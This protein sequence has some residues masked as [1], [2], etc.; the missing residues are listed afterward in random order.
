[1]TA[2]LTPLLRSTIRRLTPPPLIPRLIRA[3]TEAA[4]ADPDYRRRAELQMRFLLGKSS[5]AGEIEEIAYRYIERQ[6]WRDEL[7]WHPRLIC[8][9][10]VD[11]IDILRRDPSRP[12]ILNFM[13]HGQYDGLHPSLAYHGVP[14]HLVAAG[15][16]MEGAS[17]ARRQHIKVVIRNGI[18]VREA[19]TANIAAVLKPGVT[20]SIASDVP[21]RTAVTFLGRRVLGS[22]G[23][24]H[25]SFSTNTP[26]AVITTHPTG[27]DSSHWR[28]H[29]PLEP[30]DFDAPLDMLT[31]I[32]RIHEKAILAWPEAVD[33][34]IGR[35]RIADDADRAEFD[36]IA[37][38]PAT[39][40]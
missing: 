5:R 11:G 9:Q 38:G 27:P 6:K 28:I 30:T 37:K 33:Y 31:E 19:G 40:R 10:R 21:G 25:L 18:I 22:S 7:R 1:V 14:C 36:L 32:L 4:W 35:W 20:L 8:R 23:T 3:R 2:A 39:E 24:A 17:A 16:S 26:V 12:M 34:P 15:Q 13:H 29:E